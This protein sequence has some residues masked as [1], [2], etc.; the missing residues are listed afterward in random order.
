[1]TTGRINQVTI[2]NPGAHPERTRRG[3]PPKGGAECYRGGEHA[4]W[5]QPRGAACADAGCRQS[6]IQLPPL[7]F[8]RGGPPQGIRV[9][10]PPCQAACALQVEGHDHQSTP[11][12]GYWR[13]HS[14]LGSNR[15]VAIGHPSTDPER[16]AYRPGGRQGFGSHPRAQPRSQQKAGLARFEQVGGVATTSANELTR[17][18]IACRTPW[19]EACCYGTTGRA[20][21]ERP[22]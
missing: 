8:P 3:G 14:P 17:V 4:R 18:D 13:R 2:L 10:R 12:G 16:V 6:T 20:C 7:S 5:T 22:R 15:T 1:M 19:D 9:F 11:R 21:V